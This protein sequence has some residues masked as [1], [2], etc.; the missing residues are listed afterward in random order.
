M[1]TLYVFIIRIGAMSA[2]IAGVC[3]LNISLPIKVLLLGFLMFFYSILYRLGSLEAQF[4]KLLYF[5]RCNYITNETQRLDPE[6]KTPARDILIEDIKSKETTEVIASRFNLFGMQ[7]SVLRSIME[8]IIEIVL[9][10]IVTTVIYKL[11]D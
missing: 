7:T 5:I 11:L 2:I 10:A 4:A 1:E 9:M 6:N 8:G 3:A